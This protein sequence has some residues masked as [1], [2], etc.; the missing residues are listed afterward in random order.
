M[1]KTKVNRLKKTFRKTKRNK[2]NK[3]NKRTLSRKYNKR[4]G[5]KSARSASAAYSAAPA[6][7]KIAAPVQEEDDCPIC[8]DNTGEELCSI[9]PCGHKIH[10]TC[11]DALLN[12][13]PPH[14]NCPICRAPMTG[15]T[16]GGIAVRPVAV[17][18]VV[19][20]PLALFAEIINILQTNKDDFEEGNSAEN[21]GA[22]NLAIYLSGLNRFTGPD[23]EPGMPYVIPLAEWNQATGNN[24]TIHSNLSDLNDYLD[25]HDS[26][27]IV[28]NYYGGAPNSLYVVIHSDEQGY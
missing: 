24:W 12:N 28:S 18:P 9:V 2:R 21:L 3:R 1:S 26:I 15:L 11:Y 5:I 7:K 23:Y 14:T 27:E 8:Q 10:T 19:N 6:V 16:C 17:Q 13:V 4:G 25:E 20:P 22:K